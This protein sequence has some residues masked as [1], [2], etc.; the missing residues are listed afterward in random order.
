MRK[1]YIHI[2]NFKTGSTS[3][4]SFLFL[5]KKLFEEKN[6]NLIYEKNF[7][8]NTIHNQILFKY[9]DKKNFKKIKN[10]FKGV[11]KNSNLILSSEF[12]SCLSYDLE[13]IKYLKI[14]VTK[15]GFKPIVIFYYRSDSSYLYSLYA[16]QMT[17]RHNINIDSVFEFKKKIK[18]NGYYYNKKNKNYFMS[19]NYYLDNSKIVINWRKIFKKDFIYLKFEKRS[20]QKIFFDFLNILKIYEHANFKIPNKK[21]VSRKIKF[22]NLKRVFYLLYLNYYQKKIFSRSQ[23]NF[24]D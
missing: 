10:Y 12:F 20:G 18:K 23:L 2:G 6:F 16:Q 4:Q 3:I 15:L 21:N 5:N 24:N 9:F 8:K 19:Q 7:F 1:C 22:W 11:A 13:K 14:A 17:Q